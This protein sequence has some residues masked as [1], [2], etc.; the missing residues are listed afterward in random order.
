MASPW[1]RRVCLA[2]CTVSNWALDFAGNLQRILT[3]CEEANRRG[4]RL[5][6]GP[7]LEIPGYGCADHFFEWDTEIHSWEILKEIVEKL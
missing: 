3:T 4:A 2:V 5:R 7:E 1:N 6:L